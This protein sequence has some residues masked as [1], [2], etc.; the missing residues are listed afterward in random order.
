[1]ALAPD[2]KVLSMM[3]PGEGFGE[4]A[5]LD[6]TERSATVEVIDDAELWSLGRGHFNR[7]VKD[8]YE[9][10]ARIR[11]SR[12]ERDALARL[13]FFK[14]LSGQQLDRIASRMRTRRFA[15]GETV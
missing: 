12:A 7:W 3:I 4:L 9:I 13:P 15:D 6:N 8:R 11:A 10:A 2:G 14:G 1:S 5:L